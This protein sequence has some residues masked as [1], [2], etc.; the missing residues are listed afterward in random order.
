MEEVQLSL[1]LIDHVQVAC[2]SM[3]CRL[4][5]TSSICVSYSYIYLFPYIYIY[6]ITTIVTGNL[7][8]LEKMFAKC[9]FHIHVLFLYSS[10]CMYTTDGG[11]RT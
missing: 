9:F 10:P 8:T 4:S 7:D 5:C 11:D 6:T 3:S 1:Q 2:Q